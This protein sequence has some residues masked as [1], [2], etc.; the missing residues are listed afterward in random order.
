MSL[1]KEKAD[2]LQLLITNCH[3]DKS[4]LVK[5]PFIWRD[6]VSAGEPIM[7]S[8]QEK[9]SSVPDNELESPTPVQL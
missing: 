6:M 9:Q 3:H 7:S 4:H 5:I 1:K 2:R 8:N